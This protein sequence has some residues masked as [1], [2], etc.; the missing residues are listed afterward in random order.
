M[1]MTTSD[2]P[3]KRLADVIQSVVADLEPVADPAMR[4][5]ALDAENRRLRRAAR[6]SLNVL[7]GSVRPYEDRRGHYEN[8]IEEL[9]KALGMKP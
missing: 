4:I 1:T 9:K 6:E 8:A 3:V 2:D 5:A 7:L